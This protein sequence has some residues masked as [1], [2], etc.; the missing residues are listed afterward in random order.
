[1]EWKLFEGA[2]SKKTTKEWYADRD[3]AHHLEEN[4]H[5]PRLTQS[6]ALVQECID[7]GATTLVDLG[8]GDGGFLYLIKNHNIKS[9]GYDISY[10]NVEHA[11]NVR[12]VDAR[13]SDFNNDSL[14]DY[15]EVA[16]LTEVLEHLE[17]PHEVIT[18][19]SS[20]YLIASSP[21][22]ETDQNHY[23]HHLWAWDEEGFENLLKL[24]N[25]KIIKKFILSKKFQLVL[26]VKE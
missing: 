11:V 5:I 3:A 22:N 7:M 18:N 23:V 10:K 17:N 21:C 4:K 2:H 19:L 8:C 12:Q 24:G 6:A 15:G 25:Y 26:A 14:I 13:Y 20:K 16:V 1:M 9:W